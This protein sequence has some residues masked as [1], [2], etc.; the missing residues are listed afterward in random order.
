[1]ILTG[2]TGVTPR[3]VTPEA[4]APLLERTLPGF[5]ET[6][7]RLSFDQVGSHALL[8]RSL[9]GVRGRSLI[10]ALPGSTRACTLAMSELILPALPHAVAM[11]RGL[12]SVRPLR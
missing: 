10:F 9:A 3:D 12:H 2:G 7:R 1:M 6:F 4:L 5:G 11:I 8:S